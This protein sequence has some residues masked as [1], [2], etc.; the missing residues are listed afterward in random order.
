[1]Q[2]AVSDPE[3]LVSWTPGVW[4]MVFPRGRAVLAGVTDRSGQDA[5]VR[6]LA[7]RA[8]ALVWAQQVHG[9]GI[10]AVDTAQ[11]AVNPIPGCDALTTDLPGVVLAV[12]AAD[13]LPIL[14]WDPI[15]RAVGLAHAGW[16][17]LAAHLPSRLIML[18]RWRYQSDPGDVWVA[19]GPS[20]RACCYEVG[21]GF[22]PQFGSFLR[23]QDGKRMCDLTGC[24]ARQ[25]VEAGVPAG[26]LLDAGVCTACDGTR[27]HSVRRDGEAAGRLV[28]F[29]CIAR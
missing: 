3:R 17:G 25:I 9:A 22:P 27:W 14:V 19:I 7:P 29:I 1:M 10:A 20:I 28:S 5:D 8:A 16:R 13:C 12:R 23:E 18:M 2:T 11:P 24:A 26:H 21:E 6:A 4:R 15:R